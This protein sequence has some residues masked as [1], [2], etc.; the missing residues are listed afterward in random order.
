MKWQTKLITT[1][2]N[3]AISEEFVAASLL[4]EMGVSKNSRN[5]FHP[6]VEEFLYI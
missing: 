2:F 6:H 4:L 5:I 1:D 3:V